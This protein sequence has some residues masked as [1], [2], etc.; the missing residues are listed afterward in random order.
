[1]P[2]EEGTH[3]FSQLFHSVVDGGTSFEHNNFEDSNHKFF[4]TFNSLLMILQDT[5]TIGRGFGMDAIVGVIMIIH[6]DY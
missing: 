4:L 5:K 1:M 2:C 6:L 3:H